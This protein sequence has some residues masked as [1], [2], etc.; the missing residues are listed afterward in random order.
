M[1]PAAASKV[2]AACTAVQLLRAAV[3]LPHTEQKCV[4][5]LACSPEVLEVHNAACCCT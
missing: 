5:Q 1:L 2:Q 4:P 3:Q